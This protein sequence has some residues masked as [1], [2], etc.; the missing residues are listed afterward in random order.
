MEVLRSTHSV[1][2]QKSRTSCNFP[3]ADPEPS[4]DC[5]LI[6]IR[7]YQSQ[8]SFDTLNRGNI[9]QLF[10]H[11]PALSNV[12]SEDLLWVKFDTLNRGEGREITLTTWSNA[13][14]RDLIIAQK[15]I[16]NDWGIDLKIR[17]PPK[18]PHILLA[19]GQVSPLNSVLRGTRGMS[20]PGQIGRH[21]LQIRWA[22]NQRA[23]FLQEQRPYQVGAGSSCQHWQQMPFRQFSPRNV[24]GAPTTGKKDFLITSWN[25]AGFKRL[26]AHKQAINFLASSDIICC[27]ETWARTPTSLL[28]FYEIFQ[29]AAPPQARGRP[30]GGLSIFINHSRA[31]KVVA[32]H[33]ASASIQAITVEDSNLQHLGNKITIINCYFNFNSK[34]PYSYEEDLCME[35][36]AI[37][38]RL[39]KA[40]ICLM[41]DFNI[42][43]LD[44]TGPCRSKRGRKLKALLQGYGLL[45]SRAIM[46]QGSG[47]GREFR[48]TFMNTST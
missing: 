17:T 14:I 1:T 25:V 15:A 11:I 29:P 47:S 36:E 28:G 30:A 8:G 37:W 18:Y 45:S 35:L 22:Y 9:L 12:R 42:H 13:R 21:D 4:E 5:E 19:T 20:C 44:G 7:H 40:G 41:G 6:F 43:G 27:Q 32:L 26:S 3:P 38:S 23:V 39:P 24:A 16:F 34:A 46:R 31:L 33:S 48:P 2:T 10:A